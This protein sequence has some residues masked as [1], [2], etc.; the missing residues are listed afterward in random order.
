MKCKKCGH[1]LVQDHNP[2]ELSKRKYRAVWYDKET[3][4]GTSF[5]E[6][7]SLWGL[8]T[9]L[10]ESA[11][12]DIENLDILLDVDIDDSVPE[13]DWTSEDWGWWS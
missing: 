8:I 9:G 11:R 13:E 7:K 2:E 1:Q 10:P 4:I 12:A 6:A 3:G 5:L